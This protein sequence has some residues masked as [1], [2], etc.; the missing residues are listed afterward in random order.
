MRAQRWHAGHW[1]L[2]ILAALIM[3]LTVLA[4]LLWHLPAGG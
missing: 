1:T 4:A 3:T 2:V